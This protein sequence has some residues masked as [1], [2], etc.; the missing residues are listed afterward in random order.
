MIIHLS[1][2]YKIYGLKNN[3]VSALKNINLEI[4]SGEMLSIMGPS[5]SGKSTLMN[6]IGFLDRPTSGIY[7]FKGR[8]I[9]HLNDNQLARLRNQ[10]IGFVFQNFNLLSRSTAL[11]NVELPMI[12]A[13][14]SPG[15]RHSIAM[16]LLEVVGLKDRVNHYPNELSG[17]Q[18]QRVA[19]ARALVNHP[20]VLLADE[21]TGNLDSRSGT[22]I[23]RLFDTLNSIGV[24]VIIVTHDSDVAIQTRRIVY[25]RDGEIVSDVAST[26][27]NKDSRI[28]P[29][30]TKLGMLGFAKPHERNGRD[31]FENI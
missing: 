17:G 24:T 8:D 6:I 3:R 19:I 29:Y 10:Y 21:P 26:N 9:S 25:I 27:T 1:D 4:G 13:G 5:G 2:M 22:E 30:E 23:I 7:K 11:R 18:K 12:Y 20:A 28:L 14:I 31:G 15:K 16:E